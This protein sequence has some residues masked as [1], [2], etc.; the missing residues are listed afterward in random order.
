MAT[1]ALR[2]DIS[3][4]AALSRSRSLS[5][6]SVRS[7]IYDAC[8]RVAELASDTNMLTAEMVS[9]ASMSSWW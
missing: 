3:E 6:V 8:V 1:W 9:V 4:K 2:R 5:S 7:F